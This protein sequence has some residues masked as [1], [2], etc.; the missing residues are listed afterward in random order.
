MRMPW[1]YICLSIDLLWIY[2]CLQACAYLGCTL[3]LGVHLLE[4]CAYLG[5]ALAAGVG[6][7]EG[8]A[9]V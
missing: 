7:A 8:Q 1:M 6:A 4:A 9:A 2:I 3:A 5:L